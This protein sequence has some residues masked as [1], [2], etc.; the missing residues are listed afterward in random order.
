[1]VYKAAPQATLVV[2]HMETVNHAML[3]R[4]ELRAFAAKK[5]MTDRLKIS[6]DGEILLSWS[7]CIFFKASVQHRGGSV[8]PS[9]GAA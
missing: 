2:T 8:P 1:M 7:F 9:L 4:Y 5:G 3:M 6:E